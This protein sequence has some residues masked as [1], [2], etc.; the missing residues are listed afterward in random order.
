MSKI[1]FYRNN[2]RLNDVVSDFLLVLLY[3]GMT[4]YYVDA[5]NPDSDHVQDKIEEYYLGNITTREC[6][7]YSTTRYATAEVTYTFA[8]QR[9]DV[10]FGILTLTFIYLNGNYVVQA[11][12]GN[13]RIGKLATRVGLFFIFARWVLP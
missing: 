11:I 6:Q 8:C 2:F 1:L 13:K 4:I 12:L 9:F 7:N 5:E 3:F 10:W